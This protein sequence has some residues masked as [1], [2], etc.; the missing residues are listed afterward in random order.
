MLVDGDMEK[1]L[2]TFFAKSQAE[3]P[4]NEI[5]AFVESYN[6]EVKALA[7]TSCHPAYQ[8]LGVLATRMERSFRDIGTLLIE[9]YTTNKQ[10]IFEWTGYHWGEEPAQGKNA[11]VIQ[12]LY[13]QKNLRSAANDS[14]ALQILFEH[15]NQAKG[16]FFE[17]SAM[18]A[19]A[20]SWP[21]LTAQT[22]ISFIK[23]KENKK[24]INHFC[25]SYAVFS[26]SR[27]ACLAYLR[28]YD[29]MEEYIKKNA[30]KIKAN[31]QELGIT[32]IMCEFTD[33]AL[34]WSLTLLQDNFPDILVNEFRDKE[35][36]LKSKM[37]KFFSDKA[38]EGYL[39]NATEHK[40]G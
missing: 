2:K 15:A 35:D 39:Q 18:A 31:S 23:D 25:A 32:Y 13:L 38:I 11:E 29:Q 1:G 4:S 34:L 8:L 5:D 16:T 3:L 14:R 24:E 7:L 20:E 30:G 28:K 19:C 33:R 37:D 22:W 21:Q 9:S 10:I 6:S 36:P 26:R 27:L 17:R 40:G 12:I